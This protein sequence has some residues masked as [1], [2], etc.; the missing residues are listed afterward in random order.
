MKDASNLVA[1]LASQ[2][3][4]AD[5]TGAVK[6]VNGNIECTSCHD[7]HVQ[8]IDRI[9][10]NFLVRDSSNAQMCLACHDPNAGSAG[11]DQSAGRLYQQHSSD[12]D[13]PGF[14]RRAAPVP[15]ATVGVNACTSCH[16]SHDSVAPARL[17]RPATPAA[18][19]YDP[20]TQ[21][22]MT[23]HGGGTYLSPRHF[24]HHGGSGEDQP[25]LALGK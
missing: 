10:Q 25:S 2:G 24:E 19:S 16:M 15:Y 11:T 21:N 20:V 13:Q 1:S 9:A 7:P 17:L 5:P 8:N 18:P 4:T 12:G 6:L 3:K 23:C 14:F 22:C